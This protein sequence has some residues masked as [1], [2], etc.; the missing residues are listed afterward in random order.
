MS[1]KPLVTPLVTPVPDH[2]QQE[3]ELNVN[4]KVLGRRRTK[5]WH[6]G[7]ILDIKTTG[8]TIKKKKKAGASAIQFIEFLAL[9][10]NILACF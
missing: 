5:T 9:R 7:M 3:V 10:H 1:Q 2:V 4:M 6:P 8:K